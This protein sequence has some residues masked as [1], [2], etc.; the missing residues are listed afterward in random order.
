MFDDLVPLWIPGRAT[1]FGLLFVDGSGRGGLGLLRGR[2]EGEK[3]NKG[4]EGSCAV[5]GHALG[6]VAFL[7]VVT[8]PTLVAST[9]GMGE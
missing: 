3:K 2:G 6:S 8:G 1:E 5:E 7:V 9:A 4:C